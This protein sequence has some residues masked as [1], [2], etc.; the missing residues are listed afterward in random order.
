MARC[1]P[2]LSF[3][4][5]WLHQVA[6]RAKVTPTVVD[7]AVAA[8]A[9]GR[10]VGLAVAGKLAAG[11][12]TVALAA[13]EQL[14]LA[15]VEHCF[16]SRPLKAELDQTLAV[17]RAH[18]GLDAA[19]VLVEQLNLPPQAAVVLSRK[20]TPVAADP[21]LT[22]YSRTP[23][24][25]WALQYLGT[26]VRRAQ[27]PDWWS[28]RSLAELLENFAAGNSVYFTDCR[29]PNE[30]EAVRRAGCFTV[31]LDVTAVTQARR[32]WER[33]GLEPD[34][35]AAAHPSEIALDDYPSFDLRVDNNGGV[36][37]AVGLIVDALATHRLRLAASRH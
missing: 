36:G 12:D 15:S 24:I 37:P 14:G 33:D 13:V 11:K 8:V 10:V 4:P 30:V 28:L 3:A 7:D 18:P 25:R 20:L 27:D 19:P 2:T 26:D 6:E 34:P 35:A 23:H 16:F 17:V 5:D 1:V 21:T 32:L 9:A 29:F 22:A 31:R